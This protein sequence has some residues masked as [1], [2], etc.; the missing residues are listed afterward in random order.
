MSVQGEWIRILMPVIQQYV[1]AVNSGLWQAGD[2]GGVRLT[3]WLR[4]TTR[5]AQVGGSPSS[6]HLVALAT[7]WA[8][9]FDRIQFIRA[10]NAQGLQAIDEGSHVHVQAFTAGTLRRLGI[11]Q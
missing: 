7:D 4:D 5:N 9:D 8:G 1:A 6:Q 11:F 2:L 10:M 3:S